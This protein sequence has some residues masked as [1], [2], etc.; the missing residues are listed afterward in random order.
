MTGKKLAPVLLSLLLGGLAHAAPVSTSAPSAAAMSPALMK[1]PPH[2]LL[3]K[4]GPINPDD[5]MLTAD[6]KAQLRSQM[7]QEAAVDGTI[8]VARRPNVPIQVIDLA[9][10]RAAG[11]KGPAFWR[12]LN[13]WRLPH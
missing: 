10:L 9:R 4:K 11:A 5:P 6:E 13:A 7:L 3:E 8:R 1:A 12:L 2:L